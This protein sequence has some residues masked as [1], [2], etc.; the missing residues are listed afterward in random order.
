MGSLADIKY[1][2]KGVSDTRQITKAMETVSIAKMRKAMQVYKANAEFFK[3]VVETINDIA[4]HTGNV[5]SH[6][7][8][9]RSS[10]RV[11]YIVIS[12]DKGLCG[13]YNHNV[14]ELA[15]NELFLHDKDKVSLFTVGHMATVFFEKLGITTDVEFSQISHSTTLRNANRI[16]DNI[17]MLYDM[18][19]LDEIFIVYTQMDNHGTTNPTKLQLLP[20]KRNQIIDE[21]KKMSTED[22]YYFNE[23]EYDPNIEE[24][25]GQLIKQYLSGVIYGALVQSLAAE[26]SSRRTAMS[27]ATNNAQD[28]LEKLTLE[29][30]RERQASVTN[31]ILEI[32]TASNLVTN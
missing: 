2:M 31:E 19:L 4:L 3:K 7:M 17:V 14:L 6:Y 30:N 18:D 15:K 26:H 28:I 12:S 10:G 27:N 24:V 21:T 32:I 13:S 9:K 22:E 11:L 5:D 20:L 1:R 25:L 23:L 8:T 16:A 29:Y